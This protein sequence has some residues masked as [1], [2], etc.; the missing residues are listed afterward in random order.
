LECI[1]SEKEGL[2]IVDDVTVGDKGRE[3]NGQW[4][5]ARVREA[6]GR[7]SKAVAE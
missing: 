4:L 5:I 2:G 1:F 7:A 6:L 3:L